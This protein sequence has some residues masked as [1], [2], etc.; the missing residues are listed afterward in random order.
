MKWTGEETNFAEMVNHFCRN[1]LFLKFKF[2]KDGWKEILSD[3]KNSLY[4]L[5]MHHVM[6][7]KGANEIDIWERFIVPSAMRKYQ[8]MKCNLNKGIK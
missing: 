5:C 6:I 8:H 7:S 1:F 4:L 2:L 3:T